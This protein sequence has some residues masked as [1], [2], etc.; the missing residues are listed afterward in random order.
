M[1]DNHNR[2]TCLFIL[3]LLMAGFLPGRIC[4]QT[5]QKE[6]DIYPDTWVGTDGLGRR[7]PTSKEVGTLKTDKKRTVG[8]FYITWHDE[9]KYKIGIPY[10]ADVTKVLDADPNARKNGESK[11]WTIDSYHWGEP[12]YGYFLSQDEYVIRHDMSMLADA[13]VDVIVLDVTN[14]VLYWDE[15]KV[16]FRT[17]EQMKSEGNKVPKFCFWA[18]NGNVITVVQRLFEGIY[19]QDKYRDLWFMW[20]GKPLLL[21]NFNPT[22]DANGS[23][24]SENPNYDPD[25]AVDPGNPH[26]K[27]PDYC[28]KY[29]TDYTQ[30]VKN[31]FTMRNMWW[32]YYEW[33]GKRYVGKENNWCFGYQMNDPNVAKLSPEEL[34]AKHDGRLEEAAV[35]PAQHPISM[36]GKSWR[37]STGEPPLNDK[38]LPLPTEVP[39]LHKVVA[40]PEGYGIYFQ[41]RWNDALKADPDFIFLND[42]NEWTAGKYS[43][44]KDPSGKQNGPVDFM[45]RKNPFYF[46]D[47]YNSEFNRTIAPMKGGYTDNYYMQ[48][49]QNI[50]RYKGVRPIPE[51][52]G[53]RKMRMDGNFDKWKSV[54]P[55]YLDTRG[56]IIHRDHNGYGGNH[57]VN[58]SG[59]ND[60]IAS[61]VAFDHENVYFYVETADKLSP[62]TGKNWM[63]L[64]ID[65]D[66]NSDTGWYG[67]DYIINYKVNSSHSTT[68]MKYD[69]TS[70]KWKFVADITY[71]QS[72]NRMELSIPRRLMGLKGDALCFDFKWADDP[73]DLKNPISLCIN[74]D[75][76][77]NR[78]FNYRCI[79]TK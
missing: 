36:V 78:R 75:T 14:A 42:W 11:A 73:A 48:M 26:Y 41:D 65:A 72:G 60:I 71:R 2:L 74:G 63:L 20:D 53:I 19:K 34:T 15:W 6:V 61:K 62:Y 35:T 51:C 40:H 54:H 58:N 17:M 38:D 10:K 5:R 1:N 18:F 32:G 64:L 66:H 30:E 37:K 45:G 68:L 22:V 50:R 23:V 9:G 43:S 52:K 31:F 13:G 69:Q 28:N 7:M 8:I 27:N 77:P 79:W 46:V 39:W 4:S 59:R 12:E 67:Y 76:A 21:C 3:G 44:G 47:Q 25:A 57:Y 24:K 49:V 56:D 55:E 33:A 16:L 29:Y 70:K